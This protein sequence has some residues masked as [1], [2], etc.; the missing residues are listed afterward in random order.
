MSG[1]LKGLGKGLSALFQ[2]TQEEY[3]DTFTKKVIEESRARAASQPAPEVQIVE[4]IQLVS[5]GKPAEL[6]LALIDPNPEQPRK[7]FDEAALKEL[8]ESIRLHGIMQPLTVVKRSDRYIIVAGERRYRAS[9]L[10]GLEKVPCVI[11][12]YTEQEIKELSLIENLQRE[13]LNPI[14]A[15]EAIR[16]LMDEHSLTQDKV[17]ERIG[18]N[19]STVANLLRLLTLPP[20]ITSL[21]RDGKLSAGHARCL[22]AIPDEARQKELA[23]Y[24][25]EHSV[26]VRELERMATAQKPAP[27]KAAAKK[28]KPVPTYE[29]RDLVNTMQRVLGTKVSAVGNSNKGRITIDYFSSED[30][31]RIF[32]IFQ[33]L[34]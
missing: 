9:K 23:E 13:D 2:E 19:R 30:I 33:D 5:D 17:S 11:K 14:E 18:K 20:E 26:S 7:Y 3:E 27:K 16:T 31:D 15:A 8:S 22:V 6:P 28:A 32:Q 10:L 4:R 25:V 29:L 21:V 12:D 24:A 1:K 34:K